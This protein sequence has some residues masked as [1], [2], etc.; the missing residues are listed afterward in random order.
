MTLPVWSWNP[1]LTSLTPPAIPYYSAPFIANQC[2]EGLSGLTVFNSSSPILPCSSLRH[3]PQSIPPK[4]LFSMISILLN[5]PVSFQD[6]LSELS[7]SIWYHWL[8]NP[9]RNTFFPLT[10][11]M[12]PLLLPPHLFPSPPL[13][14][15]LLYHPNLLVDS[16]T[17]PIFCLL[18]AEAVNIQIL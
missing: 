9:S 15:Y 7:S 6:H 18:N 4:L 14:P 1:F 12:L 8:L 11:K 17:L 10:S 5:S 16:S 3:L 2:S 13:P